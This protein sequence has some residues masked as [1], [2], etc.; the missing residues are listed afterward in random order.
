MPLGSREGFFVVEARRGNVAEQVWI[1]RTRVGLLSKASAGALLVYGADLGTGRALAHMRVSFLVEGRFDVRYTDAHGT[2]RWL[3]RRRPVFAL[4]EF[5]SSKAFLSFLPQAPV[6]NAVAG[7]M[8]DS[9]VVH[10]G[11]AVRVVGFARTRSGAAFKPA[12]GTAA[13]SVR[14]RG[15]VVSDQRI[16][17]DPSGAFVS[18]VVIPADSKAGDYTVLMNAGS[19]A[20]GTVLHVDANASGMS[21]SVGSACAGTC[22]PNDD[23]PI[24]VHA[25]RN[26]MAVAGA[27]ISVE[28]I[29][30]P[31]ADV[32]TG[33]QWG[34]SRVLS[35]EVVSGTDGV[36]HVSIGRPTDGLSSTY[37]IRVS[38]GGATAATR[39]VVPTAS[40]ALR[41]VVSRAEE[42]FGNPVP[43]DVFATYVADGR[44][45]PH[46]AVRMQLVHGTSIAEQV[47]NLDGNGHGHGAFSSAELGSN[48]ILARVTVNGADA[49]DAQEVQ[50]VPHAASDASGGNSGD[51]SVTLDRSTYRPQD[52]I[53][54]DARCEG[55]TGDA[56]LTYETPLQIDSVLSAVK[57]GGATGTFSTK[58]APGG[59]QVGVAF[60]RDG[61]LRWNTIPVS[62]AGAGRPQLAAARV[63][64]T[65]FAPGSTVHVLIDEGKGAQGTTIVRMTAGIPSGSAR[66]DGAPD[67]LSIGQASSQD[68]APPGS[69]WHAWV[70]AT[71]THASTLLFDRSD[72]AAPDDISLAQADTR[73]V[74]WHVY[75][76]GS[77]DV[78]IPLPQAP[79]IYT[80]SILEFGD[81]G[82]VAS[83]SSTITVR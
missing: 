75:R 24:E 33:P 69:D 83:S 76:S 22:P 28:V 48:L 41:A 80:I 55:A 37:G 56:L 39:V 59:V 11:E 71:P 40:V 4:A 2:V 7:L 35:Q 66:F 68:T 47:V 44:P 72:A 6:P 61:E 17:L 9:A 18:D 26:G 1:N 15:T 63:T 65:E 36:A 27:H 30:S 16:A 42:S 12:A 13:L 23:V 70:D 79:G 52:R 25:T 49:L 77:G 62:L 60:V 32:G 31:H 81:D 58:N 3:Q 8:V 67:L 19:A 10:A 46:L 78:A 21:L 51:V 64:G 73:D 20:A 82:H 74:F 53:A 38:S 34:L 50:V 43:F 57:D 45:A 29:R 5:G 14:L 54:V